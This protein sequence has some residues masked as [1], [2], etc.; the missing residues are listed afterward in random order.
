M[1][2]FRKP[3]VK[4]YQIRIYSADE[5][6]HVRSTEA[7]GKEDA[8]AITIRA[9]PAWYHPILDSVVGAARSR[10]VAHAYDGS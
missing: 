4:A 6:S 9:L 10:E 1:N 8:Q 5:R 3:G 2:P 7:Q